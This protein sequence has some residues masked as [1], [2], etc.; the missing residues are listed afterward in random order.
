M[1]LNPGGKEQE[2]YDQIL[3]K[4]SHDP[5][6]RKRLIAEPVAVLRQAGIEVPDGVEVRVREFNPNCRYLFI[7]KT[8]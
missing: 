8:H 6:Y 4:V 5:Q 3:E 1:A 2:L 7:P